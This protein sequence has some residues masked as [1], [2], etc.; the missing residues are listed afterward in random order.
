MPNCGSSK[1]KCVTFCVHVFFSSEA[2]LVVDFRIL[3]YIC[4]F[5]CCLVLKSN[6]VFVIWMYPDHVVFTISKEL[7]TTSH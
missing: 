7:H 4:V 1:T 2:I 5:T 6:F 3:V